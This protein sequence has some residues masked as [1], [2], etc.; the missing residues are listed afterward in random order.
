MKTR[1]SAVFVV[2]LLLV[3]CDTTRPDDPV[4]VVTQLVTD[5]PADPYLGLGADGRP[6]GANTFT[7]FSFRTGEVVSRADSA[8]TKW[9]VAFKGSTILT[10]GGSSGPGAG[11]AQVLTAAFEDVTDVPVTGFAVDQ[12]GNPAI[13][14]GSGNSWYTYNGQTQTLTPTPGR[15]LVIRCADGTYAKVRMVS[16]YKGAPEVPTNPM[17][18]R[19]YTFE[20]S[21]ISSGTSFR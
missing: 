5:V 20:Y 18:A 8:S 12:P 1:A 7:F 15:V 11:G 2:A 14:V 17:D 6:Y 16:Y 9:D 21:Y 4:N 13:G 3:G 10:N 19:Y